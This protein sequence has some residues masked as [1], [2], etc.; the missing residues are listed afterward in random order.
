MTPTSET[1]HR[2]IPHPYEYYLRITLTL[3]LSSH[4]IYTRKEAPHF[5]LTLIAY[6]PNLWTTQPR[7]LA[8]TRFRVIL[9][10]VDSLIFMHPTVIGCPVRLEAAYQ[11]GLRDEGRSDRQIQW[12]H[13]LLSTLASRPHVL[14]ILL[15]CLMQ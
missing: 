10:D 5:T 7:E 14:S 2:P 15:E 8:A 6:V 12:C 13:H 1:A 3:S 11:S 9:F 4:P